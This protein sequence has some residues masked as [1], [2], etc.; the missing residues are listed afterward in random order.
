M[1]GTERERKCT[2]NDI[3]KKSGFCI[4]FEIITLIPMFLF[5]KL[6][7]SCVHIYLSQHFFLLKTCKVGILAN[8]KNHL[9]LGARAIEHLFALIEK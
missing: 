6:I 5:S 2:T 9:R 7:V 3:N 4:F 1:E 8:I